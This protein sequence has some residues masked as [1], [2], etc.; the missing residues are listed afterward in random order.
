MH[1]TQ[2][3]SISDTID[4]SSEEPDEEEGVVDSDVPAVGTTDEGDD[5]HGAA[6]LDE[7]SQQ[8]P[9]ANESEPLAGED[10][11]AHTEEGVGHDQ[12]EL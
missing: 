4:T 6:V 2:V 12:E 5:S 8:P 3:D 11:T 7:G 1:T 10:E 9:T